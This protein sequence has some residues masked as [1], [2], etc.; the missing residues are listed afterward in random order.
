MDIEPPMYEQNNNGFNPAFF[1][2]INNVTL[3]LS[4]AKTYFVQLTSIN[5]MKGYYFFYNNII[6][7][8]N[9]ICEY[10]SVN[11]E[12]AV[13]KIVCDT[14]ICQDLKCLNLNIP[15][16]KCVLYY[17]NMSIPLYEDFNND[18]N[19]YIQLKGNKLLIYCDRCILR[20][21]NKTVHK[22]NTS[23]VKTFFTI[24]IECDSLHF[25]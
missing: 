10:M 24:P 20:K 11:N 25:K 16:L 7:Y 15:Q 6:C 2:V 17:N 19:E 5:L 13:D 3:T 1:N 21:N 22:I 4:V 8:A 9:I 14:I 23:N 12:L 18:F